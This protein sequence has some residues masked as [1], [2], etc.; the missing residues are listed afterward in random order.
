MWSHSSKSVRLEPGSVQLQNWKSKRKGDE[1]DEN[2]GQKE[3]GLR[4][5]Q[6]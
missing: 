6:E 5:K 3:K 2:E 4:E 1:L